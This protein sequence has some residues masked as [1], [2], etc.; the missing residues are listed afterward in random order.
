MKNLLF[1]IEDSTI[2][3]IQASK[4]DFDYKVDNREIASISE[5]KLIS[6][7][8][9]YTKIYYRLKDQ[10]P[11]A[12]EYLKVKALRVYNENYNDKI[13]VSILEKSKQWNKAKPEI[14]FK[15]TEYIRFY[16]DSNDDGVNRQIIRLA[17]MDESLLS[18]SDLKM[19]PNVVSEKY[20]LV[21]IDHTNKKTIEEALKLKMGSIDDDPN[22]A[23]FLIQAKSNTFDLNESESLKVLIEYTDHLNDNSQVCEEILLSRIVYVKL[24]DLINQDLKVV[25]NDQ[26]KELEG[27]PISFG[28]KIQN[29]LI[30]HK[31]ILILSE[32]ILTLV[33]LYGLYH[34]DGMKF[35][36]QMANYNVGIGLTLAIIFSVFV[37]TIILVLLNSVL[38]INKT[39]SLTSIRSFIHEN[40]TFKVVILFSA[41]SF[42]AIYYMGNFMSPDSE[43]INPIDKMIYVVDNASQIVVLLTIFVVLFDQYNVWFKRQPKNSK[44]DVALVITT[45]LDTPAKVKAFINNSSEFDKS[46]KVIE[47][48]LP[49]SITSDSMAEVYQ[50]LAQKFHEAKAYHPSSVHLFVNAP[51]S[52]A[53]AAGA[54][55]SNN[56]QVILYQFDGST[57]QR[58]G[59]MEHNLSQIK[60]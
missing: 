57:Y 35:F 2:E 18:Q 22:C 5:G 30:D 42:M 55:A 12:S 41:V 15:E 53:V 34:I 33:I 20:E 52:I 45:N 59:M 37:S 6:K 26:I 19:T 13:S 54:L 48:N 8:S 16:S 9:G 27:E 7:K 60:R 39:W 51:V 1:D 11:D 3:S 43:I 32:F 14:S 4:T 47:A 17:V 49:G 56:M 28:T 36:I 44:N 21:K 25:R 58:F 29:F 23:Y 24:N 46:I 10:N 31:G 50:I 38:N 40:I